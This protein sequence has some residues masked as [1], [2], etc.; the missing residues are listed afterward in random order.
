MYI[1]SFTALQTALTGIE[2]AQE[3]L[4]TT[5][6]NIANQNTPGYVEQIV[7]LTENPAITAADGSSAGGQI[8]IGTGV[9]AVSITNN[10]N[11]FLDASYRTQNAASNA[12]N[13]EQSY[14]NQVQSALNEP[15][16]AGIS[17]QLQTFWSAWN[18][19]ADNPTSA[20]AKTAV[21]ADG[22]NLAQSFNALSNQFTQLSADATNQFTALT[23]A[24][25]QVVNDANQ[26]A[27]LN[28]AIKSAVG[29][30][31]TP[32]TM[33]D[34]RNA[35]LNDLSS[36]AKLTVTN[37]PD[38]T[39]AVNFGDAASPL[40]NGATVTWPQAISSASGGTLGAL[41]NLSQPGGEI[42][43]SSAGLD[44]VANQLAT[45]V[46][47]VA[48]VATPFFSGN[49]AST[50]AVA[51][52]PGQVSA[53]SNPVTSPGGNDLAVAEANLSGGPADQAYSS[54]VTSV[55]SGAQAAQSTAQ[56]QTALRTAVLNQQQ[57]FEG[58]DLSQEMANMQQE[59]QAYQAS[60]QVMNAFSTMMN[61]LMSSVG[62]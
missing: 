18:Y 13:T 31:Q 23:G 60:A 16:N 6:E 9:N 22:K 28:T 5:G 32:N 52:T 29:A 49:T 3:G 12:A 58:V 11:Q 55:G 56:T 7:N 50:L 37:N 54:F 45:E 33:I 19:L 14:L 35:A 10:G 17:Q 41:L 24:G 34:Q 47:G 8:Q 43:Q 26:I 44:N 38:G 30:G 62:A 39:V 57:S 61:A 51:V 20:A 53:T 48:G 27:Q 46:N 21:V 25:G 59:Q 36:L 42:A 40:V 4:Q 2:A 1:S 15:T